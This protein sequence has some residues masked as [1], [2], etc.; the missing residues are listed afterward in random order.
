MNG[1][2]SLTR[3]LRA[4]PT[5]HC[6]ELL[7]RRIACTTDLGIVPFMWYGD[8]GKLTGDMGR[9]HTC[10][11]YDAIKDYVNANGV[12]LGSTAYKLTPPEGAFISDLR[13]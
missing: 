7:R 11:N 5:D 8:V 6:L 9:M 10:S 13:N 3:W 2:H 1:T 12:V 4:G